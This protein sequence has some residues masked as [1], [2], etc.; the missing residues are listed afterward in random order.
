MKQPRQF[1]YYLKPHKIAR[2]FYY[3]RHGGIEKV[4]QILDERFLMGA[5]LELEFQVMPLLEGT[6][7][8]DFPQLLFKE[9][10]HPLVSIIIPVFNNFAL[11]YN[12]LRSV[13]TH[14]GNVP[15]EIIL[16]DDCST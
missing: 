9:E 15:Y 3:Y 1:L 10:S 12:C 2:I 7:I 11:T 13:L 4:S 8:S 14:S 6:K 5:D 16:A